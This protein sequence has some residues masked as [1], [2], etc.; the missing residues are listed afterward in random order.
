[1]RWLYLLAKLGLAPAWPTTWLG[2]HQVLSLL[3]C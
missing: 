1:V 3:L 2:N